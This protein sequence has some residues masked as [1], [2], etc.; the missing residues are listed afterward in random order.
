AIKSTYEN[1]KTCVKIDNKKSCHF[2]CTCGV[3]Q[4]D[5]ISPVLFSLYLNDLETYILYIQKTL[6]DVGLSNV[7]FQQASI[8]LKSLDKLVKHI[9]TDQ[10][11]QSWHANINNTNKSK[12]FNL[13]KEDTEQAPYLKILYRN[14]ALTLF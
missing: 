2:K 7:W 9:L 5:Q 8:N 3:K 6:N 12:N 1:I 4:G 11:K 14:D 10:F 13:F